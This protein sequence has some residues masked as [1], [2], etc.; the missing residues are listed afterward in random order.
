MHLTTLNAQAQIIFPIPTSEHSKQQEK[1]NEWF[2]SHSS[3]WQLWGEGGGGDQ[4]VKRTN[5][6]DKTPFHVRA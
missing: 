2:L 6:Q 1:N 3:R 4:L 5:A